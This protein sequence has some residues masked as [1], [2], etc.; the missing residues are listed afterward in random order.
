MNGGGAARRILG[1]AGGGKKINK[2]NK[3]KETRTAI[4][5]TKQDILC[6][7]GIQE[8]LHRRKGGVKYVENGGVGGVGDSGVGVFTT[9]MFPVIRALVLYRRGSH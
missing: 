1:G 3:Y 2:I 5:T 8:R 6:L 9:R 4:T 7:A